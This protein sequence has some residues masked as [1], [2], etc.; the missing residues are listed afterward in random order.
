M[1]DVLSSAIPYLFADDTKCLHMHKH[2]TSPQS[3]LNQTLLQNDMNALFNYGNSWHLFFNNTKCAHLHFHFNPG[4]DTPTYYINNMEISKKTETKDLGITINTNLHWDQ[5][6]KSITS[7][8]YKCLYLLKRTFNTHAT[9]SK[10]LLYILLVRSQ[11]IYC[12]QLWRPYLLKDI[13]TLERIQRRATKFILND[14]QSSYRFRR[15]NCTYSHLCTYLN[16]MT[17]SLLSN[18]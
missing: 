7:R 14:Y 6:Y 13:I 11:L 1:P 17:L 3:T 8:A 15:L 5:H 9:A 4:T 10:K 16:Y 2:T 12:S 18:L